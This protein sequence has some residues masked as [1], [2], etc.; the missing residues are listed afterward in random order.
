MYPL[1]PSIRHSRKPITVLR[2]DFRKCLLFYYFVF[3]SLGSNNVRPGNKFTDPANVPMLKAA[4]EHYGPA[5]GKPMS[6]GESP[7]G[8]LSNLRDRDLKC[9][10]GAIRQTFSTKTSLRLR[11]RNLASFQ[12]GNSPLLSRCAH[13]NRTGL[14]VPSCS[15]AATNQESSSVE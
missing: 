3:Q 9:G 15:L 14:Q 2:R 13:A 1:S 12:V 8:E 7:P 4:L 5:W 10:F 6:P 11:H